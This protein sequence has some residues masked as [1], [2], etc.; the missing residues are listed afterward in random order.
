MAGDPFQSLL[1]HAV[2]KSMYTVEASQ[3]LSL[4]LAGTGFGG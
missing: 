3:T 4:T 1:E 2:S